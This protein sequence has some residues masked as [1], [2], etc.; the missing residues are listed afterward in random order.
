VGTLA[1]PELDLGGVTDHVGEDE[2]VAV[3][4][5]HRAVQGQLELQLGDGR[6]TGARRGSAGTRRGGAS[7]G[8]GAPPSRTVSAATPAPS[9]PSASRSPAACWA[10]S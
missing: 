2:A 6:V 4:L 7:P 1:L 5:A 3:D 9:W 8:I 10:T